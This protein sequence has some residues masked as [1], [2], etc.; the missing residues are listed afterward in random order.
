M[1]TFYELLPTSEEG[2]A[3]EQLTRKIRR[4]KIKKILFH[5]LAVFAVMLVALQGLKS[6]IKTSE[7]FLTY[8]GKG[9]HGMQRNLS[10]L[11]SHYALPSGDKI[12]SV[13]LGTAAVR[14]SKA[15]CLT[16]DNRCLAG[17]SW[18]GW[19]CS[20]DCVECGVQAH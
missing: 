11:P 4:D 6:F 13:A 12:P 18:R 3:E 5:V 7:R 16:M 9:C 15:L 1:P 2:K 14:S 17:C 8:G 10:S 19:P 20:E